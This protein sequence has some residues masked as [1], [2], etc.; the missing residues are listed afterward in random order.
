MV[1]SIVDLTRSSKD[2]TWA[3]LSEIIYTRFSSENDYEGL[4][5]LG[6]MR[7]EDLSIVAGAIFL[8]WDPDCMNEE[9]KLSLYAH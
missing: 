5:L 2:K 3:Q 8:H 9:S 4:Y 7:W 6:Y 1:V